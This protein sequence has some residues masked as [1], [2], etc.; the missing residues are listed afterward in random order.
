MSEIRNNFVKRDL[1]FEQSLVKKQLSIPVDSTKPDTTKTL[2]IIP[3]KT[4]AEVVII[5]EEPDSVPVSGTETLPVTA[6]TTVAASTTSPEPTTSTPSGGTSGSTGDSGSIGGFGT[7]GL[8]EDE[9]RKLISILTSN[10]DTIL[11]DK[12]ADELNSILSAGTSNSGDSPFNEIINLYNKMTTVSIPNSGT[13]HLGAGGNSKGG[14][15]TIK[16]T[17]P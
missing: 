10:T 3:E 7:E 17:L 5:P 8:S 12:T 14:S 16:W 11:T 6:E 15:I 9:K 13:L 4:K 2:S 1:K